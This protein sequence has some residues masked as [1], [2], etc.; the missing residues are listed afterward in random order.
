MKLSQYQPQLT[1]AFIAQSLQLSLSNL[2]E[3]EFTSVTTD[4]RKVEL[5]SLFIA[6]EGEKMDG[7]DFVET[8]VH[9]GA[10]GV[11]CRHGV[12]VPV[13]PGLAV[14]HVT[15]TLTAYR[16]LAGAWRREF[17]IPMIAVAGSAGIFSINKM[18]YRIL[19]FAVIC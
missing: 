19:M 1:A 4:S 6:I 10:T 7:N 3:I 2:A 15:D 5:G 18:N 14:F 8:A 9:V 17:S 16:R 12:Q 13:R 11:I